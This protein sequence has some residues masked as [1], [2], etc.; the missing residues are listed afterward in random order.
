MTT[1]SEIGSNPK[2][3]SSWIKRLSLTVAVLGSLIALFY[4]EENFRH[5]R[6]WRSY[7]ASLNLKPGEL[8]WRSYLPKAVPDEQ[9]FAKTPLLE[10]A[11][12]RGSSGRAFA[13]D[14]N[15]FS[16]GA[17]TGDFQSYRPANLAGFLDEL[18]RRHSP[19]A[20]PEDPAATNKVARQVIEAY[21][22]IEPELTEL[23]EASLRPYAQFDAK[24]DD[25]WSLTIPNFVLTRS[26]S[27]M[28]AVRA[29][30]FLILGQTDDASKDI[31]VIHR[32]ADAM[33]SHHTLVS[34]MIRVAIEGLAI[35]PFWEGWYSHKWSQDQLASFQAR[36][37][38]TDLLSGVS[39]SLLGGERA[40]V[41][42]VIEAYSPKKLASIF[43]SETLLLAGRHKDWNWADLWKEFKQMMEFYRNQA[44]VYAVPQSWRY[45]N[46]LVYDR[47]MLAYLSALD[48]GQQRVY[49][50]KTRAANAQGEQIS[51][52]GG[53]FNWLAAMAVPNMLK[54][55]STMARNQTL[56]NFAALACALDRYQHDHAEYPE[57]LESLVPAY[58]ARLP[59]D[60]VSGGPLKYSRAKNGCFFLYSP[61]WD[62]RDDGGAQGTTA[63][64]G[65]WSWPGGAEP[66]S[67]ATTR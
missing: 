35:Q 23:R 13:A 61:G 3:P 25:P 62:G 63:T 65:D 55:T 64:E 39:T 30:A 10:R 14:L 59:H 57:K 46:L 56:L 32:L 45:R 58:M 16:P 41:H 19:N 7:K 20:V 43:N 48:P 51:R 47:L 44:T 17:Y 31:H 18:N 60:L 8:D 28:M 52:Q 4:A 42:H 53:R 11:G 9:N 24:G 49:A 21:K 1:P 15:H 22:I 34:A 50:E 27:Q 66:A 67:I 33:Q 6:A 5:M 37:E 26:I 29:S 36:F 38:Q 40:G 2:K 54:A 12:Y